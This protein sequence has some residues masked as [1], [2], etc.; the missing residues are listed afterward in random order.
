MLLRVYFSGVTVANLLSGVPM[1][2]ATCNGIDLHYAESGQ[3]EAVVFLNGLAGDHLYWAGQMR[4][5]SRHFRCLGVDNRDAGRSSYSSAPYHLADMADDV[6]TLLQ[7][8]HIASATVVGLSLG[9]MIAQE[10]A[11]RHPGLVRGLFLVSTTGRADAWLL[12][13]LDILAMLRKQSADTAGFF[14]AFLP[15]LVS[16]R[17]F[18]E[19]DHVDQLKVLLRKNP[20]P[21]QAEGFFRQIDAIRGLDSL[22]R[23]AAVRC[24]VLVASGEDDIL[25]PARYGRQVA[26]QIPGARFVLIPG[27]GHSAP[28]EDGRAFNRLLREFLEQD[29]G[30]RE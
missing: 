17:Y 25:I 7:T 13:V 15:W 27:V 26:E 18:A 22:D 10:L 23:L 5:C 6:A 2:N 30:K 3:G 28:M 8:L 12:G 4:A 9:A 29:T 16:Y 24:P 11:V 1:S 14:D 20:Y 21:Q 19:P